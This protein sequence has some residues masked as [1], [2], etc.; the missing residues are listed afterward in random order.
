[1]R[2][3]Y[4]P[5]KQED[6]TRVPRVFGM[7]ASP[8]WNAKNP[9]KAIADLEALLDARI[10]ELHRGGFRQEL[11]G[12][13]PKAV[14]TLVEFDA[15]NGFPIAAD[16][17]L[18]GELDD[19]GEDGPIVI[20][21]LSPRTNA[22]LDVLRPF[23]NKQGFSAIIFVE[24]RAE[25]LRLARILGAV[26]DVADWLRPAALVGHGRT[27]WKETDQ[28]ERER[29]LGM[30]VKEAS[31]GRHHSTAWHSGTNTS[32][33]QQQAI[34]AK[35]RAGEHNVLV[36]TNVAEEGLDFKACHLV[37]RYNELKTVTGYVQS[38]GRARA[39]DARYVVLAAR[40]TPEASRYRAFLKQESELQVLYAD[41]TDDPE[42]QAEPDLD[43]LPTYDTT[44]GALLTHASAISTL[45]GFCQLLK[46]DQYTPLQK[47]VFTIAA[48]PGGWVAELRVPKTAA[49]DQHLFVSVPMPTR[50]AAKQNAAFQACIALHRAGALDDHLLPLRPTRSSEAR[51]SNG[52]ALD[53]RP[54]PPIVEV[55]LV[56]PFGNVFTSSTTHLYTFEISTMPSI[57]IAMLCG[58]DVR[59][60]PRTMYGSD[61]CPFE[62]R[63]ISH[64]GVV[65][66]GSQERE[67][68]L[69]ALENF[70]R[71]VGRVVL[72]RRIGDHR[73]YAL[74]APVDAAGEVDWSLVAEPFQ[75]VDT[76]S[77]F[78]GTPLV[79]PLQRPSIR[80]GRFSAV[81]NDVTASSLPSEIELSPG[82]KKKLVEKHTDYKHYLRVMYGDEVGDVADGEPIVCLTPV[83]FRLHNALV[84]APKPEERMSDDPPVASEPAE[85]RYFPISLLRTSQLPFDFFEAYSLVPSL[86]RHFIEASVTS[87]LTS[88]FELP[89]IE[90]SHLATALTAPMSQV[91]YDY[92]SLEFVG[93]AALQLATSIHVFLLHPKADEEHLSVMRANSVDNRFLRRRALECGL[94]KFLLPHLFRP[95][96]FVPETTDDA[97]LSV[98]GLLMTRSVG[99]R[100]LSD[101][102]EALLGAAVVSSGFGT[103]LSAADRLGLCTGGVKPWSEREAAQ[104]LMNI[105]S[106]IA[107]PGLHQLEAALGYSFQTQ[108]QMLRRALTHRSWVADAGCYEREEFLGDAILEWWASTRLYA[109]NPDAP[110][111]SLTFARALLVSSGAL[112]LIGCRK[113]ELHKRILHSSPAL[114]AALREAAEEAQQYTY[115]QV[116]KGDLTFLWS[117]PKVISDVVEAIL[118]AVFIDAGFELEPVLLV[119]DRL[120]ADI[121][122]H[123]DLSSEVRDPYSRF[124]MLVDSLA[125]TSLSVSV[126]A[127]DPDDAAAAS[128][129]YEA[130]CTYHGETL[131]TVSAPSKS[132]A[133]QLAA[134]AGLVKLAGSDLKSRCAC[135]S[136]RR[137]AGTASLPRVTEQTLATEEDDDMEVDHV[138]EKTIASDVE[139]LPDVMSDD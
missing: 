115:E 5:S 81:R 13:T 37:V 72:N 36:A 73:I 89:A 29:H 6:P 99:R 35:F 30:E 21:T 33:V 138:A 121:M 87:A 109:M 59:V 57:R 139:E 113:L 4:H 116:V 10:I 84:V 107:G 96:T 17:I 8:L 45:S 28:A 20:D 128:S 119:L 19:D 79:V 22:L 85:T 104:A 44:R 1:M 92:Q 52:R 11:E 88:S 26:H 77:L 129:S 39:A 71:R 69:S 38:R 112:A 43:D 48:Q 47:P 83:D 55:E 32:D 93:D 7:T 24:R 86:N 126:T 80:F 18:G 134:Q 61:G 125:C 56:N 127:L 100:L 70:N 51:D 49:L 9:T 67:E 16:A 98:D 120:F 64:A 75:T 31:L 40:G 137:E 136:E 74:W 97:T 46:V 95:T 135:K 15:L 106:T 111:R 82:K 12:N 2:Q 118:A 34:V 65:W 114:E 58:A 25:A 130:T 54:I 91:G 105:P 62:L 122:P 108:G 124:L 133:R 66:R 68:R 110:P 50:R 27:G 90:I 42:E 63:V 102:F 78:R 76:A 53:R 23:A 131:A 132:V 41:R 3:H 60:P 101:T 103:M 123:V 94:S 117:P 14:E